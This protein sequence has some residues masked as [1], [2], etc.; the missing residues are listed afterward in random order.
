ML[1]REHASLCPLRSPT[2]PDLSRVGASPVWA[3]APY[4][5]KSFKELKPCP[6]CRQLQWP[7]SM[8]AASCYP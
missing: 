3:Q 6:P 7:R 2:A 8:P 1:A 4:E 5:L